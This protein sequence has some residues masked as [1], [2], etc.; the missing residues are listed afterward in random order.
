MLCLYQ[1]C[2]GLCAD[3]IEELVVGADSPYTVALATTHLDR[4]DDDLERTL[5]NACGTMIASRSSY[6]DA[7]TFY[8]HFGD[9]RM[10][11]REFADLEWNQLAIK[12]WAGRA[13]WNRFD[14]F[15]YH[16]FAQCNK[17]PSIIARSLD[18]YG[19]PRAK[20]ERRLSAWR[21]HLAEETAQSSPPARRKR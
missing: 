8:K 21:R 14:T 17:A 10:K 12:P 9:L 3:V 2:R 7:E 19:E 5:M 11:E 18:R 13:H 4:L 16:Q 20:V 1:Q 15:P 6:A